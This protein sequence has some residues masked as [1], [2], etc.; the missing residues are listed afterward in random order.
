VY[1]LGWARIH[2]T[3]CDA[4]RDI[5]HSKTVLSNRE[6]RFDR[7]MRY[8]NCDNSLGGSDVSL[9]LKYKSLRS[10]SSKIQNKDL[11]G[12]KNKPRQQLCSYQTN[13]FTSSTSNLSSSERDTIETARS[14]R[15]SED[16]GIQMQTL[17]VSEHHGMS[18]SSPLLILPLASSTRSAA[19]AHTT[20]RFSGTVDAFVAASQRMLASGTLSTHTIQPAEVEINGNKA[21]AA[22]TGSV[23]VRATV[24]GVEYEMVS[25]VRFHSRL[26]LCPDDS[27]QWTWKLVSLEAVYDRDYVIPTTH[28][29]VTQSNPPI[30]IAVDARESYKYLEWLL[31]NRGFFI[32][33][34]LPGLDDESSV[35]KVMDEAQE[36]LWKD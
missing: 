18:V 21:I 6:Q 16:P 9:C 23:S 4:E 33:R 8:A 3:I 11:K 26:V 36:W 12:R 13:S 7:G 31:G 20:E 34:D 15:S 10:V 29:G 17:Q 22:S 32:A 35:R 19:L 2:V 30:E 5:A 14:G 1:G 24:D 27:Q 25:L 28:S